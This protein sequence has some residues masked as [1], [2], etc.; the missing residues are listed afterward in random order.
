MVVGDHDIAAIGVALIGATVTVGVTMFI[1]WIPTYRS[2][3][4][5]VGGPGAAH[6]VSGDTNLPIRVVLLHGCFAV[7]TAT[8]T[9]VV[10]VTQR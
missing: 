7:A 3:P 9:V 1:R 8:S 5:S 10:L 6:R 4:G 2:L